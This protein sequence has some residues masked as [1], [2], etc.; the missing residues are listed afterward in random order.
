MQL[1]P[2]YRHAFLRHAP[3][4]YAAMQSQTHYESTGEKYIDH[5]GQLSDRQITTLLAGA[6]AFAVPYAANGLAH[7]LAFDIDCDHIEDSYEPIRALLD[8][9]TRRGLFAFGQYNPTRGRGYVWIPFDDLVNVT[10]IASLGNQVITAVSQ[11]GWKI[12]NRA[13]NED[14][15]LPLCRHAWTGTYGVL[16]LDGQH[17]DIDSDPAGALDQLARSYRENPTDQ[18]PPPPAPAATHVSASRPAGQGITIDRFNADH[19]L[20]DL[21]N[22]YSAQRAG[23]RLYRCPFHDD[24]HPSLVLWQNRAGVTV[25]HCKSRNSGCPLAER[26]GCDAFYVFCVGEGLTAQQAIRRLNG[27]SDDPD[28]KTG[29]QTSPA[30]PGS[31]QSSR[32]DSEI[33]PMQASGQQQPPQRTAPPKEPQRIPAHHP[34]LPKSARR[35]LTEIA[36]YPGGYIYGKHRLANTLDIDPRT[37]QRALRRLEAT[38]LIRTEQR[39]HL[40]QTDIYHPRGGRHLP[41]TW[42]LEIPTQNIPD[43]ASRGG[44]PAQLD[45]PPAGAQV[46]ACTDAPVSVHSWQ[47]QPTDR[48]PVE[49]PAAALGETQ[50]SIPNQ[51]ADLVQLRARAGAQDHELAI[52]AGDVVRGPA[53]AVLCVGGAAYV[54]AGAEAWY[55]A[56]QQAEARGDVSPPMLPDQAESVPPVLDQVETWP[57]LAPRR[58][59]PSDPKK[60]DTYYKLLGR[61]AKVRRTNPGQATLLRL[62]AEALMELTTELPDRP[63]PSPAPAATALQPH[64]R[65]GVCNGGE[66]TPPPSSSLGPQLSGDGWD[67]EWADSGWR[68]VHTAGYV[69]HCYIS[70]EAARRAIDRREYT[71]LGGA[72]DLEVER[73]LACVA[74]VAKGGGGGQAQSFGEH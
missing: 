45:P 49:S 4:R 69:T 42:N 38:G 44:Q 30:T 43:L 73:A 27:L 60:A 67:F 2:F 25:C 15:R 17:I 35:V 65:A 61:A 48:V 10:R 12:E 36:A 28:H 74:L 16:I 13:T 23:R 66:S 1:V 26:P 34:N 68:A 53:G 37:V 5:H 8:E 64:R 39:G 59:P 19:N 7:L 46:P 50:A 71:P 21:L 72:G 6:A 24:H 41:P 40:G 20:I 55:E 3:Q 29:P 63:V 56:M 18:L 32:G 62:K 31:P 51:P 47:A 33:P 57:E 11:P 14:T 22:D 70:P 52:D 58:V 54:P 9:A